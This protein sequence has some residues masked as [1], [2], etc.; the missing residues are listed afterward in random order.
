MCLHALLYIGTF[1]PEMLILKLDILICMLW[2]YADVS[3]LSLM[4]LR[5]TL[6]PAVSEFLITFGISIDSDTLRLYVSHTHQPPLNI[7]RWR[8]IPQFH[9]PPLLYTVIMGHKRHTAQPQHTT[10]HPRNSSNDE[11]RTVDKAIHSF[12][13]CSTSAEFN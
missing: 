9:K 13:P 6:T 8:P 12:C 2:W 11:R 10:H 1:C 4:L 5:L 7:G 3:M